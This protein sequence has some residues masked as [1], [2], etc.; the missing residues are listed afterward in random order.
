M[1]DNTPA[2]PTKRRGLMAITIAAGY[3]SMKDLARKSDLSYSVIFSVIKGER[4]P[5]AET[6]RRLAKAL[7][8]TIA[9]LKKLL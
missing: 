6:Q 5:S 2:K 7:N 9:Q 1:D 3:D 4:F 8:L